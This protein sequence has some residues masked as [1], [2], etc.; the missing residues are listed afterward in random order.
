MGKS[1]VVC[2]L[3][4]FHEMDIRH[5]IQIRYFGGGIVLLIAG[6]F[7]SQIITDEV[8]FFLPAPSHVFTLAPIL[9]IDLAHTNTRDCFF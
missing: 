7:I 8:R 6:T 4:Y 1:L 5:I 3:L 9:V 2:Y